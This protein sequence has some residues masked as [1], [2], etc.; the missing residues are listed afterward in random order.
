MR[1]D[2]FHPHERGD[3]IVAREVSTREDPARA[4]LRALSSDAAFSLLFGGVGWFGGLFCFEELMYYRDVSMKDDV[5]KEKRDAG[6]SHEQ[7]GES[8]R[9][10]FLAAARSGCVQ[11]G[12]AGATS[13][14]ESMPP[15][16]HAARQQGRQ[17]HTQSEPPARQAEQAFVAHDPSHKQAWL[18]RNSLPP[19]ACFL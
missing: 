6:H 4:L 5:E 13:A 10:A 9:T 16:D 19:P 11:A 17:P 12:G 8:E 3:A 1:G 7:P 2:R 18:L 15:C 14:R